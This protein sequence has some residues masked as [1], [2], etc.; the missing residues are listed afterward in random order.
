MDIK[1]F[2]IETVKN[3]VFVAGTTVTVYAGLKLAQKLYGPIE[4]SI[5]EKK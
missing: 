1:D 5:K 3:L 2:A 4:V